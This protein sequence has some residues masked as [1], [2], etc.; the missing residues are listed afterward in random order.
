MAFDVKK[1]FDG[2]YYVLNGREVVGHVLLVKMEDGLLGYSPFGSNEVFTSLA[3][4]ASEVV[5]N[6]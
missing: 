1:V 6:K 5:R 2:F 4:A 3:R